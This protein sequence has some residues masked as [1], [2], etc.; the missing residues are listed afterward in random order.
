MAPARPVRDLHCDD[1]FRVAAGKIIWSRCHD[2]L[3][4]WESAKRGKDA[5]AI[6]DMRV[7]SRRLRAALEV[8]RDAF[9][10]RRLKPLLDEVKALADALGAVRDL[11][12]QLERLN[13][14]L[15]GRP[16]EQQAALQALIADLA[17]ERGEARRRL[18]STLSA[19]ESSDFSRRFLSFVA[20]EA[21]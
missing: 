11:D 3:S 18:K 19:A 2:M 6:H 15:A 20:Q 13:S 21:L 5:D 14:D 8:F 12:V 10:A 16:S 17:V 1:E 7:A 4:F 9:P